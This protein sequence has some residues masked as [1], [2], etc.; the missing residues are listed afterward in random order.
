MMTPAFGIMFA[1]AGATAGTPASA[2][3]PEFDDRH[4][5]VGSANL[6]KPVIAFRRIDR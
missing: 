4:L 2:V 3:N 1:A 5:Q 6:R